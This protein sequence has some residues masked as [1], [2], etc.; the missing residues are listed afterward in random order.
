LQTTGGF[1]VPIDKRQTVS[2]NI[3]VTF[4]QLAQKLEKISAQNDTSG[5]NQVLLKTGEILFHQGEEGDS[6]YL[7]TDGTLD[8]RLTRPDGSET[9]LNKLNSG[10]II[11]D[12]AILSR[13]KRTATVYAVSDTRLIRLSRSYF[14]QLSQAEQDL[15]INPEK[16][17]KRWRRQQLA[18]GLQL[19]FGDINVTD[20][21]AW[22]DQ[23]D[24][25]RLA[26]GDIVFEQGALPDGMYI[27]ITGRVRFVRTIPGNKDKITGEI[28]P[29]QP[30]GD[31][32]LLTGEPRIA[33]V[34]TVRRTDLVRISLPLFNEMIC[35]YP[36][37]MIRMAKINALRDSATIKAKPIA[38]DSLTIAVIAHDPSVNALAF[39]KKFCDAL[40]KIGTSVVLNHKR[41]Q[42]YYNHKVTPD[43]INT[44]AITS[45]MS[46]LEAITQYVLL[47]L[48]PTDSAWNRLC[49]SQADQVLII[50]DPKN[51][52]APGHLEKYL[53][54]LETALRTELVLWHD[55]STI[56][57]EGT[58]SWLLPR[59][60]AAHHHVREGSQNHFDRLARR[61]SGHAI[62]LVLS[63]GGAR[64]FAHM[65][66]Q[67]AMEELDI[68]I[69]YVGCASM[70]AV[71]GGLMS[72]TTHEKM[73]GMAEVE[74]AN[75]K[76]LFDYTLPFVSIMAS[77]RV[78]QM[79]RRIYGERQIEDL[80]YPFF[81]TASNITTAETVVIQN[82]PL[83]RAIRSSLAIP[84]VFTPVMENKEV[85]VDGGILNN[86]PVG[87][88]AE[89]CKT[90][91]I[92]GA[93]VGL[94]KGKKRDY[95]ID[96]GI[97]GWQILLNRLNP[98]S[99]RIKVP[100]LLGLIMRTMEI[101]AL[102]AAREQEPLTD[103]MVKPDVKQFSINEYGA[104]N[105]IAR[106]GYDAALKPLEEW[107][108]THLPFL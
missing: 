61:I 68:P 83:W 78:T 107:K 33:A 70:G 82:G 71:L 88:T 85:L 38:P 10:S 100:S 62:A 20:L 32:G 99:R 97:S 55:P 40:L 6:I 98:F 79:M 56:E 52:P 53:D 22:Q 14:Y 63:G 17:D 4:D 105:A 102:Q 77:K 11:G 45:I 74:F 1:M 29:G 25:L 104:F 54:S 31:F 75:P 9:I 94:H 12:L 58:R 5:I 72:Y 92:I 106:A 57:P 26:N 27:V 93:H 19:L 80:W 15:L 76:V 2:K 60:L 81:C 41:F 86:F 108:K 89:M 84:G 67:R 51:D 49:I 42:E 8:V 43:T 48:D 18:E 95:D 35:K 13:Q 59:N 73:L 64:G 24:W 30:F 3:S 69:D 23:M 46:Q 101:S 7:L 21:H 90:E 44:P 65:G 66:V 37:T 50:A 34:E 47:L 87:L 96:T 36:G 16:A 39:T 28:G 103:I 91:H